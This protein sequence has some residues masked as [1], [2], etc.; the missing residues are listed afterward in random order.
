MGKYRLNWDNIFDRMLP[1][2]EFQ[3]KE[4]V[5]KD[6][7]E[8]SES[9]VGVKHNEKL[10][11]FEM[12]Y[13][14]Y[15][16]EF[17]CFFGNSHKYKILTE[18]GYKSLRDVKIGDKVLTANKKW[19][20]VID[21][22]EYDINRKIARYTIETENGNKVTVTEEHPFYCKRNETFKWVKAKDLT[23]NDIILEVL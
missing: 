21:K 6:T 20:K 12:L 10:L 1:K 19:K 17:G 23:E 5:S 2:I 9:I 11:A 4:N 13:Y 15:Y 7:T 18:H 8:L 3:L 22:P 14:W 16:A